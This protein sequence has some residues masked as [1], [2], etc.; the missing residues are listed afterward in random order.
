MK[1]FVSPTQIETYRLCARKY[2]FRFLDNLPQVRKLQHSFG[3]ILHSAAERFLKSEELW[4][5][6]WDV[7]KETQERLE[8]SEAALIQVLI[9][10]GINNGILERRPNGRVE[11]WIRLPVEGT[12][13]KLRGLID[14]VTEVRVE[15]HKS[16]KSAKYLKSA[17][18]LKKD[19][20][21]MSYAK[22]LLEVYREQGRKPPATL[23]VAH[24]QFIKDYEAPATKRV[25]AEVTPAEIDEFWRDEVV[26]TVKAMEIT[27]KVE[28]PFDIPDPPPSACNAY[29][30]CDYCSICGG[31][32]TPLQFKK[33]ISTMLDSNDQTQ[34]SPMTT[35]QD[36][37][38]RRKKTAPAAEAAPASPP[39]INPPAPAPAPAKA[40]E[41]AAAA[42]TM[43][44]NEI[45]PWAH[46][47]CQLCSRSPTPGWNINKGRPCKIC[48]ATTRYDMTDIQWD[49]DGDGSIRW[50][51]KGEQIAEKAAPAVEDKGTKTLYSADDLY[52]SIRKAQ[53]EDE[54]LGLIQ[55][56]EQV[57][58]E[59]DLEIFRTVAKARLQELAGQVS[60]DPIEPP[61]PEAE[62]PAPVA[63][64]PK[65]AKAAPKAE[66]APA[67]KAE[68]LVLLIGCAPLS[69]P[70]M[71]VVFAETVLN[72]LEGYWDNHA[73]FDRREKLRN[74]IRTTGDL[75]KS[76]AGTVIVQQGRDPDVD[77]LMS[78]LLP[79]A[80]IVVRG[81]IQ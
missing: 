81:T 36:F 10:E 27:E 80:S 55:Q 63:E 51:R 43:T 71:T 72:N 57:L 60:T 79:Y 13:K 40:A 69:W 24:N 59:N 20:Q 4:P 29:G 16:S 45:P 19:V 64:K 49:L 76:M 61:P 78:S 5:L 17:K 74:A 12:G 73:A 9:T 68:G 58:E 21:M 41:P 39:A 66:A 47:S 50:W 37:L 70:G 33:R 54:I 1:E 77:N 26:E 30:G 46:H 28:N 75:V 11:Q 48:L 7:D 35:P 25:E 32:E 53:N 56:A 18:A 67:P 15:D 34:N 44:T 52:Q 42:P 14:Y 2:R 8:P 62:K 3:T 38:S 6:G 65:K 31:Q 22:W 23:T